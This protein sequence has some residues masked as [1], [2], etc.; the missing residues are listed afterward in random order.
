MKVCKSRKIIF[1]HPLWQGKI[2]K[3]LKYNRFFDLMYAKEKEIFSFNYY[4]T[5]FC[6]EIISK[7]EQISYCRNI[8]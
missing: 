5:Y 7:K 2:Q 1:R 6:N 8:L 4:T 3:S